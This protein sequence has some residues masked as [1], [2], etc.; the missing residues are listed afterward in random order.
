[1]RQVWG[2]ASAEV[3]FASGLAGDLQADAVVVDPYP[4]RG[5]RRCGD[6]DHAWH[7][8]AGL[9][10]DGA[11]GTVTHQPVDA[12]P[13]HPRRQERACDPLGRWSWSGAMPRRGIHVGPEVVASAHD[14]HFVHF[15]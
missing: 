13:M 3:G 14:R 8:Q 5:E 11:S 15:V 7:G 6:D 9:S 1:V 4:R 10:L 2:S 12:Y